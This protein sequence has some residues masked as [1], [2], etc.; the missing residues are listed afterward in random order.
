M[1]DLDQ[2]RQRAG[3]L[4]QQKRFSQALGLLTEAHA[5][6]PDD[7]KIY[8][9]QGLCHYALGHITKGE[10][11]ADIYLSREPNDPEAYALKAR[12]ELANN[13][14]IRA[15][16]TAQRGLD[17][18][19]E[20]ADLYV[21]LGR[22]YDLRGCFTDALDAAN[23]GL[24][25]ESDN[26]QL[27]NVRAQALTSLQKYEESQETLERSLA[28]EP[29]NSLTHTCVGWNYLRQ[30]KYAEANEAYQTALRFEPDNQ[31]A[32][33]GLIES[34]KIRHLPYRLFY[35]IYTK[36]FSIGA[37]LVW[38]ALFLSTLL[39]FYLIYFVDILSPLRL[40]SVPASLIMYSA[41]C[42]VLIRRFGPALFNCLLIVHPTGRLALS[43]ALHFQAWFLI[44]LFVAICAFCLHL[45]YITFYGMIF[46]TLIISALLF[47]M[48]AFASEPID[49]TRRSRILCVSCAL[50]FTM[51]ATL[52]TI[53][54]YY[55]FDDYLTYIST[56]KQDKVTQI[57]EKHNEAYKD[58]AP[59][60]QEAADTYHQS[61]KQHENIYNWYPIYLTYAYW[62]CLF[63]I[64][65]SGG[66]I[67]IKKH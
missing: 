31:F 4:I 9:L 14:P 38:L 51:W 30:S 25:I 34:I 50:I 63:F 61:A 33:D 47:T 55:L 2:L 59:A 42:I 27:L 54:R 49:M 62:S 60:H 21:L 17:C 3:I 32:R 56:V 41:L 29:E 66:L 46:D 22:A 1:T 23:T 57:P 43:K 35:K 20:H 45:Y 36:T 48:F 67:R 18:D 19:P 6:N 28:I 12:L 24:E 65:F 39:K 5:L 52:G 26:V 53:G 40:L 37:T 16:Q 58:L 44:V 13:K 8:I 10:E 64:I 15:T 11:C 7:S